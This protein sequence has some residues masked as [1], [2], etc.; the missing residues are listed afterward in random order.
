MVSR[1]TGRQVSRPDDAGVLLINQLPCNE[2]LRWEPA[3][4]VLHHA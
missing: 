2:W 4:S 3:G 1:V